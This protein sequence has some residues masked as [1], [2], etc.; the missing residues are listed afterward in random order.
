LKNSNFL[1]LFIKKRREVNKK[2]SI[3]LYRNIKIIIFCMVKNHKKIKL[4]GF[5]KNEKDIF[6]IIVSHGY[7][8]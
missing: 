7:G 5:Y 2:C 3:L 4:G 1:K 8:M 6:Y